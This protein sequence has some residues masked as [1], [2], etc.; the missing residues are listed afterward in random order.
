MNFVNVFILG[1]AYAVE[2]ALWIWVLSRNLERRMSRKLPYVMCGLGSYLIILAKQYIGEKEISGELEIV[3][4]ICLVCYYFFVYKSLFVCKK[5]KLLTMLLLLYILALAMEFAILGIAIGLGY[6][7][8]DISTVGAVNTYATLLS[9]I[10]LIL[11]CVLLFRKNHGNLVKTLWNTKEILPILAGLVVMELPII[12]LFRNMSLIGNKPWILVLFV[13]TQI[14]L[15]SLAV[16]M[17]E[18]ILHHVRIEQEYNGRIY[19]IQAEMESYRKYEKMI[20]DLREMRHDLK[21]HVGIIRQLCE[22]GEYDRLE[23]Y[24]DNIYGRIEVT[25][26]FTFKNKNVEILLNQCRNRIL[27]K[28][29][30]FVTEIMADNFKMDALDICSLLSNILKNA[31]EATEVLPEPDRYI[32]LAITEDAEG[33]DIYC[34]NTYRQHPVMKRG[35]YVSTKH[36]GNGYGIRII[37]KIAKNHKGQARVDFDDK[38]FNIRV[39]IPYC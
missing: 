7:A 22:H 39:Y 16:Y 20:E 9:K 8:K 36:Q 23:D 26:Y 2:P 29:I 24:L 32:K 6:S 11:V 17:I 30:I 1:I 25:E 35:E 34:E 27:E 4:F 19:Y 21:N 15:M 31:E 14:I 37:R 10:L 33:L 18:L 3:L 38:L 5:R 12:I 13:F 28:K